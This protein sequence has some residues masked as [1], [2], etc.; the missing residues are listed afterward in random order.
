MKKLQVTITLDMDIPDDWMLVDHPD[1]V[2]VL[3]VGNGRYMYLSFLPMFAKGLEP[4]SDW[5]SVCSEKFAAEV[6]DMVEDEIVEM[7]IVVN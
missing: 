6:V 7:N 1:G 5:T 2:P 3:T 4:E